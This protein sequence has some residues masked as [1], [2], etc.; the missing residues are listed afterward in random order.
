MDFKPYWK[1]LW[2]AILGAIALISGV[3]SV[4]REIVAI[5]SGSPPV[6]SLFWSWARIAF[7]VS[8]SILWVAE[9]RAR[10]KAEKVASGLARDKWKQEG[11][12]AT[13]AT[14]MN[15]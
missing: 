13:F 2:M 7:F 12:K 5:Y 11:A 3:F 8:A 15:E 10:V 9:Y 6:P 14:L 1:F 4:L